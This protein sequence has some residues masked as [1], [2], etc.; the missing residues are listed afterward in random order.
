MLHLS[1]FFID[2]LAFLRVFVKI[3]LTHVATWLPYL[4]YTFLNCKPLIMKNIYLSFLTLLFLMTHMVLALATTYTF[5]SSSNNNWTDISN[6]NGFL[7][8][9]TTISVGDEVIIIG[10][11]LV[12]T[13]V[14]IEGDLSN[15]PG[16]LFLRVNS[17]ITLTIANGGTFNHGLNTLRVDGH[18]E[19][20]DGGTL[21]QSGSN[22]RIYGSLT[23]DGIVTI[24]NGET[25]TVKNGGTFTNKSTL[26]NNGTFDLN[27]GGELVLDSDPASLPG[28]TFN[29]QDGS[30][31]SIGE[32]GDLALSNSLVID[33]DKI[34][35]VDGTLRNFGHSLTIGTNGSLIVNDS[36]ILHTTG[37]LSSNFNG[38]ITLNGLLE[39]QDNSTLTNNGTLDLNSEG[40]IFFN[41]GSDSMP[42]GVFNWNSGLIRIGTNATLDVAG[43]HTIPPNG[44]L[45]IFGIMELNGFIINNGTWNL[46]E[47]GNLILN[48]SSSSWPDGNFVWEQGSTMTVGSNGILTLTNTTKTIEVGTTLQVDG[49]LNMT[50]T[51][52]NPRQLN[53]NGTLINNGTITHKNGYGVHISGVLNN[54]NIFTVKNSTGVSKLV[55]KNDGVINNNG[56]LTNN[57]TFTVSL[58]G[59]FN[60][61]GS[62]FMKN[63]G[64]LGNSGEIYLKS[65]GEWVLDTN[66]AAWPNGNFIWETGSSMTIGVD[67]NLELTSSKT[68]EIG[69]TLKVEGVLELDGF[70]T[71]NPK[72]TNKG[73]FENNGTVTITSSGELVNEGTLILNGILDNNGTFTSNGI[74]NGQGQLAG[75]ANFINPVSGTI[76]PGLS[77]GC[78]DFNTD[79]TNSGFLEIEL[80]DGNYCDH[81]DRIIVTGDAIVDGEI[82][83]SFIDDIEPN[84]TTFT[85]LT[86]TGT[87]T[88]TPT[89]NWPTGYDGDFEIDNTTSPSELIVTFLIPL[90]VELTYF[91]AGLNS[92]NKVR[93]EWQTASEQNNLGFEIEHSTN[94]NDWEVI[95]FVDG[96]GTTTEFIS[97]NFLDQF[98]KDGFNYYRLKQIDFDG[99]FEYS[100]TRAIKVN[101]AG[102]DILV[103]PNPTSDELHIDLSQAMTFLSQNLS[104]QIQ[105]FNSLG[106]SISSFEISGND[107]ST[108]L[109]LRDYPKGIY[110]L[111]ISIG[112]E[113]FTK[114]IIIQ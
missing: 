38:I 108:I 100:K 54:E 87:I 110:A 49:K 24:E 13:N 71:L 19:I 95:G 67:G 74:L 114:Q 10:Q 89:I 107:P 78:F 112:Q 64:I 52:S 5:N 42:E 29:W 27:L 102:L 98:P 97:Y 92:K 56:T 33:S 20:A 75:T 25:M 50:L 72:L 57:R 88:G 79:F 36:F 113:N 101:H 55:I 94:N 34:L 44:T 69:N 23:N 31:I 21:T 12:N 66:P 2:L 63:N 58:G 104:G 35:K 61:H 65:G 14:S 60:N 8:P 16:G 4:R 111:F 93:L 96:R 70:F 106:T 37:T 99:A 40:Q 9:G 45:D 86:A 46:N 82:D 7:Y 26:I 76:S 84:E 32:N 103:Y 47:V 15:D 90:P 53:V 77:P 59:T 51:N 17:G 6:W 73:T 43:T 28:G 11:C 22:T 41:A 105:L 85:I 68:I 1:E 48:N 18:L 83:I 91:Q 39:F 30:T 80:A 62:F 3:I 81:F 109:H